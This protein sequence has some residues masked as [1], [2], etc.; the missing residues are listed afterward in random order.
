MHRIH[1]RIPQTRKGTCMNNANVTYKPYIHK[2]QQI[3]LESSNN[4]FEF[5]DLD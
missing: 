3:Y 2:A 5:S 4:D 1:K